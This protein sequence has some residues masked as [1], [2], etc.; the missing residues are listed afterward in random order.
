[1]PPRPLRARQ[2]VQPVRGLL[3]SR[4]SDARLYARGGVPLVSVVRW[5]GESP[6]VVAAWEVGRAELESRPGFRE[7]SDAG[8]RPVLLCWRG[9]PRTL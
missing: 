5:L 6:E 3:K 7:E 8:T 9:E 2:L 1:M 4:T